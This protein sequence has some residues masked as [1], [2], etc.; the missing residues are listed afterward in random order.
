MSSLTKALKLAQIDA[1]ESRECF[2]S[3]ASFLENDL[4]IFYKDFSKMLENNAGISEV[5]D[6]D[7]LDII[8]LGHDRERTTI[9]AS[10]RLD[11]VDANG[12]SSRPLVIYPVGI[13]P[14]LELVEE[15]NNALI[16]TVTRRDSM[17]ALVNWLHP[18]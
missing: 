2:Y 15:L 5:K 10:G 1:K 3:Q 11:G 6:L 12:Y 8:L 4:C 17:V 7:G 13:R 14:N 9:I 16:G 18:E